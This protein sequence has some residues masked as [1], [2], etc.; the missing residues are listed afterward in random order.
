MSNNKSFPQ[1]IYGVGYRLALVLIL[2]HI[3]PSAYSGIISGVV[4]NNK[5][6][7]VEGMLVNIYDKYRGANSALSLVYSD[8]AGHFDFQNLEEG[9]YCV[10][11]ISD[12]PY[13]PIN[14]ICVS[15][16]SKTNIILRPVTL[17]CY[18]LNGLVLD[19]QNFLPVTN[20]VVSLTGDIVPVKDI[21]ELLKRKRTS[22]EGIFQYSDIYP[23]NYS[24]LVKISNHTESFRFEI[25]N[26]GHVIQ[27]SNDKIFKLDLSVTE[28]GAPNN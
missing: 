18:D 11:A 17:P 24:I 16:R 3:A 9:L 21:L 28:K 6:N 10:E 23:G 1:K 14:N 5:S 4:I 19:K 26:E 7:V 13:Q 20:A 12:T 22:S 2:I 27:R 8:S 25:D 15:A